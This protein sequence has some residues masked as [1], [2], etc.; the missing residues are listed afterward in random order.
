MIPYQLVILP[1][2]HIIKNYSSYHFSEE[3]K[4]M[5][6]IKFQFIEGHK[7]EHHF[8]IEKVDNLLKMYAND[9]INVTIDTA[10]FLFDWLKN[11][12]LK[13]DKKIGLYYKFD[14]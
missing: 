6:S 10:D 1:L 7:K 14:Y 12:I 9:D 2:I 8:F 3:E 4:L 5:E 13:E 11:H